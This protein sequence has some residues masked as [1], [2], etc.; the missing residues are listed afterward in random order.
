MNKTLSKYIKA[1]NYFDKT[2]L[3]LSVNCDTF[4]IASF[5]TVFDEP[6]K[7]TSARLNLVFS[8]I[9]GIAKNL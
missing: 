6:V 5:T 1:F 3:V 7:I 8:M 9:N 2:L 4:S